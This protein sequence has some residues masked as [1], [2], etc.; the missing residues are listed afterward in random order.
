MP[1][2]AVHCNLKLSPSCA[3][4]LGSGEGPPDVEDGF[5]VGSTMCQACLLAKQ[6]AEAPEVPPM[7]PPEVP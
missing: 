3:I 6:I 2:Y 5:L 4:V 7:A 1:I